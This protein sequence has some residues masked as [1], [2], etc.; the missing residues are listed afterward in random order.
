MKC[1]TC[2]E[3]LHKSKTDYKYVESGLS[4]VILKGIDI[5]TCDCGEEFIEIPH[6]DML[7]ARIADAI[8][9]KSTSLSAQEFKFLRKQLGYKAK[10]I[11]SIFDVSHVTVSR[12][13]NETI[14]IPPTID[15]LIRLVYIQTQE[16]K[17]HMVVMGIANIMTSISMTAEACPIEIDVSS[18]INI[19]DSLSPEDALA[20]DIE[21][22]FTSCN[23]LSLCE[24]IKQLVQESNLSS[25]PLG[26]VLEELPRRLCPIVYENLLKDEVN[27]EAKKLVDDLFKLK[28]KKD[29]HESDK[30]ERSYCVMSKFL[31]KSGHLN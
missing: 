28:E 11:A 16:E 26:N 31:M 25:H 10:E 5:Y 3:T 30:S 19:A 15:K 24:K 23:D 17:H 27:K 4:N 6:A 1:P 7:H 12:W 8:V 20:Q 22:L 21:K 29:Y 9:T 2:G 13:E 14:K 18:I